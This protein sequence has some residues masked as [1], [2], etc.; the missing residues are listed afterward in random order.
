MDGL[1][2]GVGALPVAR[3]CLRAAHAG[4]NLTSNARR[5][6]DFDIVIAGRRNDSD[7]LIH[8]GAPGAAGLAVEMI[9]V[10]EGV[11]LTGTI[12]VDEQVGL[13]LIKGTLDQ[14]W[15][16]RHACEADAGQRTQV[17]GLELGMSQHV[18]EHRGHEEERCQPLL[19]DQTQNLFRPIFRHTHQSAIEQRR[20]EHYA[21]AHRV[22]ERHHAETGIA[23]PILVLGNVSNRRHQLAAM[24]ARHAFWA[25][26]SPGGVKHQACRGLADRGG[27]GERDMLDALHLR[28]H[29]APKRRAA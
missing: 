20:A 29:R 9:A 1:G 3:E 24:A 18:V 12:I 2:V 21:H 8:P 27:T 14:R 23:L 26:R 22:E 5:Q 13:E 16:H 19:G 17:V 4:D 15:A 11:D 7:D 6:V 28:D 25:P 10:A